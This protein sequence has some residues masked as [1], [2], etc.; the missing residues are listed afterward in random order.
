MLALAACASRFER[1]VD[2]ARQSW[3][4]ATYEEVVARWGNPSR[5]EGER[6]SWH[7]QGEPIRRQ[8]M[9]GVFGGG[10]GVFGGASFPFGGSE[11][12]G[13]RCDRTLTFRQGRVV[14]QAWTGPADY[15]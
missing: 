8:P 14:D 4:G 7:T 11:E 15:C 1:D 10:G 9:V 5:S 6:H 3:Q 12:P 2:E 13:P